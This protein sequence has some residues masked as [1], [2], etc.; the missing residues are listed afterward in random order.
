MCEKT[1][2]LIIKTVIMAGCRTLCSLKI[3]EYKNKDENNK[4]MII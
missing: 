3:V 4:D 1:L 2:L